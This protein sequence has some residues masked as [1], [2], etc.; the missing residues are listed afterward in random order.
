MTGYKIDVI[1]GPASNNNSTNNNNNSSALRLNVPKEEQTEEQSQRQTK[2]DEQPTK[3]IKSTTTNTTTH[4][5]PKR[6]NVGTKVIL[7]MT[8]WR[9]M[10]V[11][12]GLWP[13]PVASTL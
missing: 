10:E 7:V 9:P 13:L 4:L 11:G 1:S 6:R 2:Y 8:L 12:V 3:Q 5:H